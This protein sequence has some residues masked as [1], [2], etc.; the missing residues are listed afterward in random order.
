MRLPMNL[1]RYG[2]NRQAR[3]DFRHYHCLASYSSFYHKIKI[4]SAYTCLHLIRFIILTCLIACFL[5]DNIKKWIR[6]V[7]T[8]N[9]HLILIHFGVFLTSR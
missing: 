7:L 1:Y 9:I 5:T 2:I 3:S 6:A 8:I 4:Q